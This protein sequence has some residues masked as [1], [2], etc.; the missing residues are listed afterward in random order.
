MGIWGHGSFENDGALDWLAKLEADGIEAIREALQPNTD[1]YI[2]VD[3]ASYVI[4]AAEVV[5]T[6]RGH[7]AEDLPD[8]IT[9]WIES[10]V[11]SI[12]DEDVALAR[13]AVAR[14]RESS[15]LQELW[16]DH[17][18]ENA[19]E[20]YTANLLDRLARSVRAKSDRG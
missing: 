13:K 14:I 9:A 12:A 5:A 8:K 19:W 4:A 11:S 16:A 17:G 10:N 6:V 2:E 3:D 18:P 1:Q 7:G 15:E 20:R